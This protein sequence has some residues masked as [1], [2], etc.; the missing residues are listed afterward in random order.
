MK[1]VA[2][3]IMA[4]GMMLTAQVVEAHP[5]HKT[6]HPVVTNAR[7]KHGVRTGQL[8]PRE[9]AALRCN[10]AHVRGMKRVARADGFVSPRERMVINRTQNNLNRNI[11]YKKHNR[12]GRGC[13]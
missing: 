11:Y 5:H 12:A 9:T 2:I 6:K 3:V 1:N 10:Q 7:I 4:V 13:R 8:T